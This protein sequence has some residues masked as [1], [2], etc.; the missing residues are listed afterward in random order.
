M[1]NSALLQLQEESETFKGEPI[2]NTWQ[3]SLDGK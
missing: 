2:E 1:G 3:K